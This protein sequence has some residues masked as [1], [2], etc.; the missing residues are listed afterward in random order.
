MSKFFR[1]TREFIFV[2][3]IEVYPGVEAFG[4][5]KASA[6]EWYFNYHFPNNPIMPGVFQMEAIQQTAGV[7]INT[8]SGKENNKIYFMSAEKLRIWHA[9]VPETEY[10]TYA[11]A[12]ENRRGIWKFEGRLEVNE[13]VYCSMI[14]SL[15]DSDEIKHFARGNI[16]EIT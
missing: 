6:E 11:K 2:D 1:Q 12:L 9:V 4:N 15:I 14:F 5:G 7:I 13:R 8:I 10:H 16:N 3:A